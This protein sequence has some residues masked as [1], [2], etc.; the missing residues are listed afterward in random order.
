[1]GGN[2]EGAP[3]G[4][5]LIGD[6][7]S[8][9][10]ASSFCGKEDNIIQLQT[11]W[12]SVGHVDEIFK[13]LPSKFQDGRPKECQFTLMAASPTKAF[14]LMQSPK[15]KNIAYNSISNNLT[16]DEELEFRKARSG[17]SR[18]NFGSSLICNFIQNAIIDGS[19]N[20]NTDSNRFRQ[21]SKSIKSVFI[22]L[23]FKKAFAAAS[24]IENSTIPQ[25]KCED[26]ID[27]IPNDIIYQGIAK[28]KN[29]FNLN[30]QIQNS[31]DS[32]KRLIKSKI[33]SRLP[34]CEKYFDE[35][36]VP[37]L[38]YGSA[39]IELD[40][41]MYLP[42]GGDADSFLPNPTNSVLMNRTI[43]LSESGNS[44]FDSFVESELEKRQL[45][46]ERIDSWDYAHVGNGNI[47]CSS[48]SIPF[49]KPR[50]VK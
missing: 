4:F 44:V 46:T 50:N 28:D 15:G 25:F 8:K 9:N 19:Y 11:S 23:I 36:D 42:I 33:L 34:Q 24:P 38:F 16:K 47:H 13:I 49:C 40:G 14:E 27:K 7:L 26:H 32:D 29:L 3:G 45:K 17:E 31:I 35:L 2:V 18:Y 6:N 41:K 48:H 21:N 39:P 30:I 37:N 1:M 43:L 20:P 10:L 5:C 12:L 22:D